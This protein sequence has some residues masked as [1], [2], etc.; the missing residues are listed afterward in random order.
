MIERG[1]GRGEI[2]I[3]MT[4]K[5]V[6]ILVMG[7]SRPVISVTRFTWWRIV[8]REILALGTSVIGVVTGNIALSSWRGTCLLQTC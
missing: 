2:R 8:Q 4:T 5:T 7:L 3:S 6:S 1:L